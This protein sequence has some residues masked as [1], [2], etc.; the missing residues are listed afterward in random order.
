MAHDVSEETA[1]HL[2][3]CVECRLERQRLLEVLEEGPPGH[4]E[5]S[6]LLETWSLAAVH[7]SLRPVVRVLAG[8]GR[9]PLRIE[10][11]S[12]VAIV[13]GDE[14]R[15]RFGEHRSAVH[16]DVLAWTTLVSV[17]ATDLPV[18]TW[19]ATAR[20]PPVTDVS[21]ALE[22]DP[23]RAVN[24]AARAAVAVAALH[25]A[26][27][28]HG[29][30]ADGLVGASI[31]GRLVLVPPVLHRSPSPAEDFVQLGALFRRLG[32]S[33]PP[34][35]ALGERLESG[36]LDAFLPLVAELFALADAGRRG[37]ARYAR[38]AKLG[39]GGGGEVWRTHDSQLDRSVAVK[40]QRD[41]R[42]DD[43]AFVREARLT[44]SLQHPGIVSIH[45][46]GTLDDGRVF[47][48]MEEVAGPDLTDV[49]GDLHRHSAT[50]W[51][52]TAGGWTL[53]RL[54]EAIA[55]VAD[56]LGYAHSRGIVHGDVKPANIKLGQ[57]G[58]VRL[59]DWGMA[60]RAGASPRG[61]TPAYMAPEQARR[62]PLGPA[63]D[64][65]ALGRLL[66]DLLHG[67]G[68]ARR[69]P[70][71]PV[72]EELEQLAE[73]CRSADPDDR[74]PDGATVAEDIRAWLDGRRR[75][76][77][78]REALARVASAVGQADERTSRA[79]TLRSEARARL[80]GVPPWAPPADKVGA[81]GLEDEAARLD[82]EA[83]VHRTTYE[84]GVRAALE[85]D[86]RFRDA[87]DA[88]AAIFQRGLL[89]AEARG[90]EPER[91]RFA[92][93]LEQ[94]DGGRHAAWIRGDGRLSLVT[95]PPGAQVVVQ[96]YEERQRR[97]V[98]V[99]F[100]QIGPTP[101]LDHPLP[102]G[103]YL[104]RIRHPDCEEVRLPLS[105]D[106]GEHW[107]GRDP[108]GNVVPVALPRRGTLGPD[109]CYVPAGWFVA[110][111]DPDAPESLPARRLWID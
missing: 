50:E 27:T 2:E 3:S 107:E 68:V 30:L 29:A 39:A 80:D 5:V 109:E 105:L 84:Q 90:D 10:D 77:R 31:D 98:P 71:P 69:E 79:G 28:A 41:D 92:T 95:E 100:V 83:A 81:W 53:R 37:T 60:V 103:H 67:P 108:D 6:S 87:I 17:E 104:L 55:R 47:Y 111:G 66:E 64:V 59:M 38:Q 56:A 11:D 94:H 93:L 70:A 76:E 15:E 13:T 110:G 40:V 46:I 73:R 44:A 23:E 9:I 101:V 61:G 57:H 43:S 48:T 19:R 72:P 75:R 102:R 33:T 62:E 74:P 97:L 18:P 45:Q 7:A 85:L 52:E 25:E 86:P 99:P 16:P 88:L 58:E 20:L 21:T 12:L 14:V 65:Y 89:A 51:H 63:A 26:G 106:R 35:E 54:A 36:E 82:R 4:S 1:R 32:R 24:F 96:R 34:L 22:V 49:L 91:A 42:R 8:D 78:A